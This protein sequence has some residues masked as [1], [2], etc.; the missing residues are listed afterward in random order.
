MKHRNCV[1]MTGDCVCVLD[2]EE[3]ADLDEEM[4]D[5]KIAKSYDEAGS[6]SIWMKKL[7]GKRS[8]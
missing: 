8:L 3:K 1:F 6:S 4:G 2:G 5:C 7:N